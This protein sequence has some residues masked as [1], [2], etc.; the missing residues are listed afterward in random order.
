MTMD[1]LRR[2]TRGRRRSRPSVECA[3]PDS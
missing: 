1:K 3:R 2:H